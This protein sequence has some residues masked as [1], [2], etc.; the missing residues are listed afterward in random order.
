[1]SGLKLVLP[2]SFTDTSLPVLRDDPLLTAG[3]LALIE[4]AHPANP[5]VGVPATAALIPNIA[6]QESAA[7]LG[8]ADDGLASVFTIGGAIANG[9][10]GKFERTA[11]GGLHGIVSQS[12]GLAAGDGAKLDLNSSIRSWLTTHKADHEFY[13]SSWTRVTRAAIGTAGLLA[14]YGSGSDSAMILKYRSTQGW[15]QNS[16]PLPAGTFR[17]GTNGALGN[18]MASVKTVMGNSNLTAAPNNAGP[19]WG[20]P[21]GTY[22]NAVGGWLVQMPS[23]VVYRV[24]VED[25]TVSGRSYATVDALDFAEYTKHVL[26]TG[27]RY[28]G[29]T[30]P[31]DPA[32]IP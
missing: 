26:T 3:S 11:K 23:L 12:P 25:L 29:D 9:T 14:E 22:N 5:L 8:V 19:M 20:A 30:L 4:P 1:M 2:T 16:T 6:H 31:T 7:A 32:T 28:Y 15:L 18:N 27:G 24:Y 10:K 17:N 21:T 13:I